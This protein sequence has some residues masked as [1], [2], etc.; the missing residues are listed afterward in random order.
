[1]RWAPRSSLASGGVLAVPCGH[2]CYRTLVPISGV[3]DICLLPS[4]TPQFCIPLSGGG[5]FMRPQGTHL[6]LETWPFAPG[7]GRWSLLPLQPSLLAGQVGSA[8]PLVSFP[9]LS[10]PPAGHSKSSTPVS[11]S[12]PRP[13]EAE[14]RAHRVV[15][16]R[17]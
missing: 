17:A 1:M 13:R 14:G 11:V 10:L 5:V 15:P 7:W 8:R 2:P 4:R 12:P 9:V 6:A 16:R 3:G